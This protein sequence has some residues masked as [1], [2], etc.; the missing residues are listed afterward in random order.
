VLA[1]AFLAA[2]G[3]E[4]RF[5]AAAFNRLSIPREVRGS[6]AVNIGL[7]SNSEQRVYDRLTENLGFVF[8]S[9]AWLLEL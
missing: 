8:L 5:S 6:A 4:N 1:N 3:I 2:Q 7:Y 9:H